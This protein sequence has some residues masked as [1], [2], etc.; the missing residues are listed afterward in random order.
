M[1]KNQEDRRVKRTKKALKQSLLTLLQ[2]KDAAQIS[3]QE[4]TD[5]ADVN[6]AT[7][8]L[9]YRDVRDLLLQIEDEAAAE[10]VAIMEKNPIGKDPEPY[11]LFVELLCYIQR[12]SQL[13]QAMLARGRNQSFVD[14][15][16][17]I[18]EEYCLQNWLGQYEK[19]GPE[20]SM[21]YFG[22]YAVRGFVAVIE[23]WVDRGMKE[24]PEEMAEL[25]GRMGMYG[26]HFLEM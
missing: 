24:S 8:Y 22:T 19:A 14:R 26:I 12:E 5:L 15:M 10:I 13:C 17:G 23:K 9:H 2:Q 16:C 3:V 21:A 7:F 20:N 25:M 18:V 6:R 11:Q 4:L 1:N